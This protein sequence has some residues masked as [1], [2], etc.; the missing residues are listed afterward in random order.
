M[1]WGAAFGN[2]RT[3]N[4]EVRGASIVLHCSEVK[5]NR[6]GAARGRWTAS[7]R[8]VLGVQLARLFGVMLGMQVMAMRGMRVI[9]GLGMVA[10]GV[11]RGGVLV[12]LGGLGVMLGSGG[13]MLGGGM[14]LRHDWVS[15]FGAY[16]PS[17]GVGP[18]RDR[19]SGGCV[20]VA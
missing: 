20:T 1:G 10:R 6:P 11:M 2:G 12:V 5:K 8:V 13:M 14:G 15:R 9:G 18:P 4:I 17:I 19:L 3:R 16:V 7:G